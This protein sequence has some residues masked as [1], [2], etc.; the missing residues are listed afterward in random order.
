MLSFSLTLTLLMVLYG[1]L[2]DV[3][4]DFNYIFL[5]LHNGIRMTAACANLASDVDA[6]K[7]TYISQRRRTASGGGKTHLNLGGSGYAARRETTRLVVD[8]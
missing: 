7:Y 2:A 6:F 8:S 3:G 4:V 5:C 1:I